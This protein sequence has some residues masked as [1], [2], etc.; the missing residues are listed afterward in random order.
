MKW[1]N[2]SRMQ[3]SPPDKT[4]PKDTA[5]KKCDI[6]AQNEIRNESWTLCW[7]TQMTCYAHLDGP[8][9]PRA[10]HN[11]LS[12]DFERF[13][14]IPKDSDMAFLKLFAV[15]TKLNEASWRRLAEA[16]TT[17]SQLR[18]LCLRHRWDFSSAPA[19]SPQKTKR[20]PRTAGWIGTAKISEQQIQIGL[21]LWHMYPCFTCRMCFAAFTTSLCNQKHL[22]GLKM[23][24]E[25]WNYLHL[26][27]QSLL[28]HSIHL[29]CAW[30]SNFGFQALCEILTVFWF[31][32]DQL[33]QQFLN[34]NAP[35]S[36]D[37][38]LA[39]PCF[40]VSH[41]KHQMISKDSSVSNLPWLSTS[42]SKSVRLCSP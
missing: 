34:T 7:Q 38:I 27:P 6:E 42:D 33:V 14:E 41:T 20:I 29:V 12:N 17:S 5:R 30:L 35:P 9:T 2:Q 16:S 32:L 1:R 23:F 3:H 4:R 24:E 39:A 13:R 22:K 37:L 10:W 26:T 15:T 19:S 31:N 18:W 11:Q 21:H 25:V 28:V 8:M 36:A 40:H